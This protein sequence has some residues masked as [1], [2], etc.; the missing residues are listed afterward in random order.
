[1]KNKCVFQLQLLRQLQSGRRYFHN[2][3]YGRS[4]TQ[5]GDC[6]NL[7]FTHSKDT[8]QRSISTKC[9]YSSASRLIRTSDPCRR[10]LYLSSKKRYPGKDSFQKS[11]VTLKCDAISSSRHSSHYV[12][13]NSENKGKNQNQQSAL[14]VS[15]SDQFNT[16]TVLADLNLKTRFQNMNKLHEN[17][18]ARGMDLNVYELV[19]D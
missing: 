6:S 3:L 14:Y 4:L 12:N 1:M 18:M 15:H 7:C 8:D 13:S 5:I 19:S 9:L 17:I 11:Y 2:G 10:H 16:T